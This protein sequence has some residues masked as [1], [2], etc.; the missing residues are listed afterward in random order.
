MRVENK[1][2]CNIAD[3]GATPRRMF[4]RWDNTGG[5]MSVLLKTVERVIALLK[6]DSSYRLNST[7]G[8]RELLAVCF[9]RATQIVRGFFLRLRLG[10]VKGIVFCGRNVIVEHAY[11]LRA[12]P[13]LILE[14]NV[15]INA[16]GF[17]GISLGRNVTIAESAI[18]ICTGVL[19]NKGVGIRIGDYSAIG[20]QSFLGGQGGIRMGNNVIIGAGTRIFS[21]NHNFQDENIP[22]RM[23]GETRKGVVIEDDCWIGASVTILDG[24]TIRQGT[25]VAAGAV[26]TK[27]TP[28]NSVI[29]GV[30]AS[31]LKSRSA[32]QESRQHL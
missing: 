18:L 15:H 29:A 32:C 8:T 28:A 12:D 21:E 2:R 10:K 6:N 31:F 24:V 4:M 3:H 7:Y 17:E 11:N 5:I 13:S 27:D 30:P 1:G 23:Q 20:A 9:Q 19:L 22:I 16:L 25:V 26:V 14:D